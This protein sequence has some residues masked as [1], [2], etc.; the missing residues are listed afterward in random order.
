MDS[1]KHSKQWWDSSRQPFVW[2]KFCFEKLNQGKIPFWNVRA[3]ILQENRVT[4]DSD[5]WCGG[6]WGEVCIG[7]CFGEPNTFIH[8]QRKLKAAPKVWMPAGL[9]PAY[10]AV[11]PHTN[12]HSNPEN[13]AACILQIC[14]K[15][16]GFF[17]NLS[18]TEVRK[19]Q[20]YQHLGSSE[21]YNIQKQTEKNPNDKERKWR[22]RCGPHLSHLEGPFRAKSANL[23][24]PTALELLAP[25]GCHLKR[26]RMIWRSWPNILLLL[27]ILLSHL[28]YCAP[29]GANGES[30]F[31]QIR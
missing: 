19:Y 16:F 12:L 8:C 29:C 9:R 14:Q 17:S 27:I 13:P 26:Q 4:L 28:K 24:A 7:H 6:I 25:A 21:T 18:C 10:P 23:S 2:E 30:G 15:H 1:T 3:N 5:M 11:N 31:C 20:P 22:K